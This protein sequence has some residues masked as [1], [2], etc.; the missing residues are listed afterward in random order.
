MK[1]SKALARIIIVH[2]VISVYTVYTP[3]QYDCQEKN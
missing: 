1:Y 2:S 3:D